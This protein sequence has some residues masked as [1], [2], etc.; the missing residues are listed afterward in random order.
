MDNKTLAALVIVI[1]LI[2]G[3]IFKLDYKIETGKDW[4]LKTLIE[5]V[6]NK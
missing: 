2:V 5:N 6:K 3:A 1:I 4:N